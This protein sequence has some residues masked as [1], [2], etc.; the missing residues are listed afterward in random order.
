MEI[1]S[2]LAEPQAG[3]KRESFE[4]LGCLSYLSARRLSR[5]NEP[6]ALLV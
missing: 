3:R 6:E 5:P 4:E 1:G 2:R